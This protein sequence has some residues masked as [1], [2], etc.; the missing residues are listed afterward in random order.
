MRTNISVALRYLTAWVSE[1]GAVAIDG[2]MEDAA[3][4]EISRTQIWQWLR[5]KVRTAEGLVVT[6]SM[7]DEMINDVVEELHAQATDERGHR[8]VEEARDTFVEAALGEEL[9]DF[10]TPYAYVRY[11][12]DRP[13]QPRGPITKG[14]PAA[15][16]AGAVRRHDHPAGRTGRRR[17]LIAPDR[18]PRVDHHRTASCGG[19]PLV[20]VPSRSFVSGEPVRGVRT[21]FGAHHPMWRRCA[22]RPSPGRSAGCRTVR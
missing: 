12:I 6:R 18:P 5:Y 14:R 9:P 2:L 19:G 8:H 7:V 16:D 11:L 3:T 10:F 22:G 13:L 4:V 20:V 17:R 21:P 15:V 1:Q